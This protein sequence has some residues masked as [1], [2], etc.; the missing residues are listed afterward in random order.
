MRKIHHLTALTAGLALLVGCATS[1]PAEHP[2]LVQARE[3]YQR[4]M[5]D[6]TIRDNA[7]VVLHEAEQALYRAEN[8]DSD[9]ERDHYAYLVQQKVAMAQAYARN[10][11]AQ[12][13]VAQL[14]ERRDAIMAQSAEQ[15][16]AESQ[17]QAET[18]QLQL[19][20]MREAQRQAEVR[21]YQQEAQRAREENRRLEQELQQMSQ[22]RTQDTERG[23][24][25]SIGDVLFET[26]QAVLKPGAA[27]NL[28][29]L[30]QVLRQHPERKILIEGHTDNTGA[31]SYNEQ[32]SQQRAQAVAD[33]LRGQGIPEDRIMARGYGEAYPVASNENTAGRQQ[34]R[35]VDIVLLNQEG[36]FEQSM[37]ETPR[38]G[39]EQG[40]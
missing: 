10:D 22:T 29:K 16:A 20:E 28:N 25:L 1:G 2:R 9:A 21:Q 24:V 37:R 36:T 3:S 5:R 39:T 19:R 8:A 15:R 13:E 31:A 32:L 40:S 17:R 30:V 34:N 4:A 35:R 27:L 23:I 38:A 12:A 7:P 6:P 14:E 11:A 33:F 18:A 26:N